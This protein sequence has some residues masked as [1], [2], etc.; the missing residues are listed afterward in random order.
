MYIK[1]YKESTKS[2]KCNSH[3]M[4]FPIITYTMLVNNHYEISYFSIGNIMDYFNIARSTRN[5]KH[6]TECISLLESEQ[7]IHQVYGENVSQCTMNTLLGFE[8]IRDSG[9]GKHNQILPIEIDLIKDAYNNKEQNYSFANLFLVLKRTSQ[10]EVFGKNA[11]IDYSR[12][13]YSTLSRESGIKS[14]T[15]LSKYIGLLEEYGLLKVDRDTTKEEK[16]DE[17]TGSAIT[18]FK[19]LNTYT[20]MEREVTK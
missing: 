6:M 19:T 16:I 5:F 8:I 13:S 1:M 18:T 15:T 10:F 3:K 4:F 20:F 7:L 17:K 9:D 11:F 12:V 2:K 14:N